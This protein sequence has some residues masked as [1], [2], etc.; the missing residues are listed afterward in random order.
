M[1]PQGYEIARPTGLCAATGVAI[2]VGDRFMAALVDT[3]QGLGRVDYALGAWN[4][5][6]RPAGLFACWR[7]KMPE[8][9]ARRKA[10]VEDQDLAELF[11]QLGEGAEADP[12]RIEFRYVLTWLLVR[13][14]LLQYGGTRDGVLQVRR[15]GALASGPVADEPWIEVEDPG[16]SE[17]AL[18]GATRALAIAL[19]G[20][21]ED[22]EAPGQAG[23]EGE[24]R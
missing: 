23:P 4:A 10:L 11:E 13:R 21:D 8:P 18:A 19:L 6:S 7:A 15:S 1:M 14:K 22:A 16:L 17:E 2:E 20:E 24:A 5:G 3:E 9:R 12:R